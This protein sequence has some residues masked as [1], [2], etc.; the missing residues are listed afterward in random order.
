MLDNGRTPVQGK[1]WMVGPLAASGYAVR[2]EYSEDD[3]VFKQVADE[4]RMGSTPAVIYDPRTTPDLLRFYRSG[5]DK[6]DE[7]LLISLPTGLVTVEEVTEVIERVYQTELKTP[8]AQSE[9]GKLWENADKFYAKT[10]AEQTVQMYLKTGLSVAFPHCEIRPEQ[11]GITGRSDLEIE[12]SDKFGSGSTIRHV[13]IE[14]KVLREFGVKGGRYSQKDNDDWIDSGVDQAWSYAD[15]RGTRAAMLCC[16][17]MRKLDV[18]DACFAHVREKAESHGVVLKVWYIYASAKAYRTV[19]SAGT[20][21]ATPKAA[22]AA[23]TAA[24]AAKASGRNI[25]ST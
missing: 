4:Y 16:F 11:P 10:R 20:L 17:D 1:L 5:L 2:L 22:K 12:E 21:R 24:K 18:G 3:D 19:A 25:S 23:K 8:D 15:E 6:P 7:R 9:T 13:L 14:L